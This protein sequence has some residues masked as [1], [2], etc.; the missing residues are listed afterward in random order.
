MTSIICRAVGGGQSTGCPPFP[1]DFRVTEILREHGAGLLVRNSGEFVA[2]MERLA[3]HGSE[4][5]TLCEAARS[6]GQAI[7]WDTL[8][9]RYGA[10]VFDVYLS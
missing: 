6:V 5:R 7:D 8:A 10:E 1:N 2:A 3:T 9:A 4:L